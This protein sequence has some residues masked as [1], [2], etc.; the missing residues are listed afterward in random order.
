MSLR[1]DLADL[2]EGDLLVG[3]RLSVEQAA[4]LNSTGLVAA[5][6][7]VHGWRVKASH[8]VGVVAC[9]GFT[10]R[11][12]PKVGPLQ[13]LRLLARAHGIDGLKVDDQLVGIDDVSDLTTALAVMFA[14]EGLRALAAGPLRGYRTEDQSL[15]ALRGRVRLRDQELRRFGQIVPI[16]VT[17]DEWT[18]DTEENRLIRTACR[19]LLRLPAL[20]PVVRRRLVIVDR[21]VAEAGVLTPG[22]PIPRWARTRLNQRFHRLLGLAELVLRHHTIEHRV[23]DVEV[24]GF[25]LSM[26][27]L[28]EK[29]VAQI[30][31]EQRD[32]VRTLAQ[33][34]RKLDVGGVLTIKPDL[35][36]TMGQEVVG[37]ADTKYK[38]LDDTG[39]F[40]N[41]DA[42]Q[43]VT[44]CARLGLSEG[45][46]IYAAGEPQ[47]EPF[48]IIGAGVRLVIHSLDMDQQVAEIEH[49]VSVIR[50]R[51]VG[52]SAARYLQAGIAAGSS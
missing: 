5:T 48:E 40:P 23:G 13:V 27:W 11:V 18:M 7:D 12:R 9:D 51:I 45:H 43:L 1:A 21:A 35:V 17:V 26:A 39:R 36:F 32:E 16:E 52:L 41:A 50:R 33:L 34:T 49:D 47:P 29:L 30:L 37:V 4:A 38:I 10:V 24:R 46:L 20:P 31:T 42:Y 8:A 28:F 19:R 14:Q 6:P 44:Y 25:V 3:V 2:G 22:S 15:T